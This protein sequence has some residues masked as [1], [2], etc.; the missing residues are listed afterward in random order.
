MGEFQVHISSYRQRF[1]EAF[2]VRSEH[3]AS[4]DDGMRKAIAD[5]LTAEYGSPKAAADAVWALARENEW[6]KE[7]ALAERYL[8]NRFPAVSVWNQAALELIVA[9]HGVA[10]GHLNH[11]GFEWRWKSGDS[12]DP[13]IVRQPTPGKLPP[14][15]ASL[16]PE[17]WLEEV[18]KSKDERALLRSG[19][20]YMSNIAIVERQSDLETLP[21]DVLVSG[22]ASH[23]KEG[24]FTGRYAGPARGEIEES[25]ERSLAKIYES[26]DAPRLSGIQIKAPMQKGCFRP[27]SANP[28]P[29]S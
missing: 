25:F 14:F 3:A 7:G 9:W 12:E 20:R 1:L 27:A 24:A 8:L 23:C 21:P 19:K 17:G 15:I 11:D 13:P 28:S 22:L 4:M 2:R 6:L 16:L 29:T 5:R 10:I 18:L 26:A